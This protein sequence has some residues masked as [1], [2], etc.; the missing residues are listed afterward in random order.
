[1]AVVLQF[2][3]RAHQM[4]CG[5]TS[6]TASPT[7]P[8]YS[9]APP[10]SSTSLWA[11]IAKVHSLIDH[12]CEL[13]KLNAHVDRRL[14]VLLEQTRIHMAHVASLRTHRRAGTWRASSR[15]TPGWKPRTA[16]ADSVATPLVNPRPPAVPATLQLSLEQYYA[17]CGAIGILAAQ[18]EEP[19]MDWI[20]EQSI[21]FGEKMAKGTRRRRHR[22]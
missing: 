14:T 11:L 7:S 3:P 5:A 20:I 2:Q 19:D 12:P 15:P 9:S 6:P 21:E 13:Q 17:G 1:M 16:A 18:G 4:P 10:R 8:I 22:K